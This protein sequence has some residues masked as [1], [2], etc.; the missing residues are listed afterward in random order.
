VSGRGRLESEPVHVQ[1]RVANHPPPGGGRVQDQ[2]GLLGRA[3]ADLHDVVGKNL[4]DQPGH[5]FPQDRGL[6][7]GRIVLRQLGDPL[8]QAPRGHKYFGGRDCHAVTLLHV[9]FQALLSRVSSV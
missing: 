4:P 6:G 1:R 8:E 7:T 5:Y 9:R 2:A 3:G